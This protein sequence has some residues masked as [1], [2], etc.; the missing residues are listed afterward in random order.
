[1]D[2]E[3]LNTA[4]YFAC[5]LFS[6]W[7]SSRKSAVRRFDRS[8]KISA[9]NATERQAHN[10][11]FA[12]SSPSSP[13]THSDCAQI[14]RPSDICRPIGRP[15]GVSS[16]SAGVS[17]ISLEGFDTFVSAHKICFPGNR[18]SGSKRQGSNAGQPRVRRVIWERPSM[19]GPGRLPIREE[20]SAEW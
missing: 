1:M 3:G 18:D 20:F 13:T 7:K 4:N 5:T 19:R 2:I 12:G 10:L 15:V 17:V 16:V 8:G 14:S 6:G 11:L 9:E